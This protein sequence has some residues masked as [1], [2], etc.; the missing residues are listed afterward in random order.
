MFKKI[1]LTLLS[2][3]VVT[4]FIG[5]GVSQDEYDRL[6]SEYATQIQELQN[7]LQIREGYIKPPQYFENRK[8][9]EYWLDT[10]LYLGISKDVEQYYQY[11]LYYQQKALDAGY[12]VSVALWED[13]DFIM[14]WCEV[15]TQDGW[16]YWFDPDDCELKDYYLRVDMVEPEILEN[17][18]MGS[19]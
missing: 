15:I 17:K 4:L 14:V 3:I 11:A 18:Y 13:G 5:C 10:I 6:E 2:F 9:I 19:L 16:I 8:A 12:I 1:C 7:E